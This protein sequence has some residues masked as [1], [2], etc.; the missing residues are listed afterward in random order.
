MVKYNHAVKKS[1]GIGVSVLPFR[2]YLVNFELDPRCLLCIL[3]ITQLCPFVKSLSD[4]F[5][6]I[7]ISIHESMSE[8]L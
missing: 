8:Q 2:H 7:S 1:T 6:R 4:D 3:I 5:Y